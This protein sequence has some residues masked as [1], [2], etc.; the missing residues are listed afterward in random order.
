MSHFPPLLTTNDKAHGRVE[1]RSIQVSDISKRRLFP[2]ACQAMRITRSRTC[3]GETSI[4]TVFAITSHPSKKAAPEILLSL[5]RGHWAIEN[6]VHYVR[7]VSFNEDRRYHRKNAALFAAFNNLAISLCRLSGSTYIP[8]FQ[9]LFRA[10]PARA[11]RALG[12]A[13]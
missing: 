5:N 1:V 11:L 9:R 2:H 10:Y 13:E 7:D 3:K 4:E 8:T 6:K 12:V